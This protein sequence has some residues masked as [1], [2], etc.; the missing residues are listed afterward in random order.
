MKE[1]LLDS[2]HIMEKD[3]NDLSKRLGKDYPPIYSQSDVYESLKLVEEYDFNQKYKLN[4]F[5][6]FEFLESGHIINSAQIVLW[7][8]SNNSIK[9]IGFTSDLGNVSMPSYYINEFEPIKSANLLVGECTYCNKERSSKTKDRKKDLEKIKSALFDTLEDRQ[10]SVLF[11]VFAL[12]RLEVMLTVLY[13]IFKDDQSFNYPIYI[14]SPLG[15]KIA[16]LFKED[17]RS[18]EQIALW[19]EVLEWKNVVFLKSFE[20]LQGKIKEDQPSIYLSPAG[21]CNSGH[22]VYILEKLL[23]KT[24]NT[25]IFCGYSAQGTIAAKIKNGKQKTITVN[26]VSVPNKANVVNL[27]SFSSHMP[28]SKLLWYYSSF[29]FDKIALVHGNFDDKVEFAKTVEE[30]KSKKNKSGKV[31]CVNKSTIISL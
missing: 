2:M 31:I 27:S 22:A 12:H 3:A 8:K 15:K 13:E 4:D 17:L 7:I 18:E 19:E 26:G 30:E 9:K 5:L 29:D 6:E 11:P 20:E 10:G 16:E 25:I 24:K 14:S 21:M 1:L 23:P 28:Y